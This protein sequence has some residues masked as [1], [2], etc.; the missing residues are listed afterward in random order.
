[1]CLF[2]FF[3]MFH[4]L[5]WSL[6]DCFLMFW[7]SLFRAWNLYRFV[8]DCGMDLGIIFD[9]FLKPFYRSHMQ[10]SKKNQKHL[11]LQWISM[12]V[13]FRT[14]MSFD[15]FRDFLFAT[16]CVIDF[17]ELWHR[18]WFHFGILLATNSICWGDRFLDVFLNWCLLKCWPKWLQKIYGSSLPF[19]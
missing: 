12:I 13:P 4:S 8:I 14:N 6:V 1:M 7:V 10:P 17:D 5:V 19:R 16:S 18:C 15:I 11:F 3:L 9:V 2:G